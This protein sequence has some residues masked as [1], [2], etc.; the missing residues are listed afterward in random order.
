[1]F[2][3]FSKKEVVK[4]IE[5]H[6]IEREY[7]VMNTKGD[8]GKT[9]SARDAKDAVYREWVR[10]LKDG[11]GWWPA[12]F[13]TVHCENT[14][15]IIYVKTVYNDNATHVFSYLDE[16]PKPKPEPAKPEAT[17]VPQGGVKT[18]R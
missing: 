12:E 17:S 2:K 14:N 9:F 15:E 18:K 5:I 11:S 13:E 4:P 7:A 3:W 16:K 10:G 1:M 8:W 6:A